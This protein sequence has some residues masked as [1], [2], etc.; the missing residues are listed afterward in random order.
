LNLPAPPLKFTGGFK[1]VRLEWGSHIDSLHH[2]VD[3]LSVWTTRAKLPNHIP[4]RAGAAAIRRATSRAS[5]QRA[6][7]R[8]RYLTGGRIFEGY[9]LYRSEDP[10][11]IRVTRAGRC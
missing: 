7:V 11:T 6:P 1:K 8:Q 9:R 2:L 5:V 3:P 10:G 4:T